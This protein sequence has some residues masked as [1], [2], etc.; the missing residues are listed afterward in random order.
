MN[1]SYSA[2][3]CDVIQNIDNINNHKRNLRQEMFINRNQKS[4]FEI[5]KS[6][7]HNDHNDLDEF[8]LKNES[9][10]IDIE[11]PIEQNQFYIK[12]EESMFL[13]KTIGDDNTS[14]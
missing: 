5:I 2:V 4:S 7:F 11:D 6:N 12:R 8:Q 13:I 9:K 1:R 3:N 14:L 10:V